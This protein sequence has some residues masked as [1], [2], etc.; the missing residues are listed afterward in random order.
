MVKLQSVALAFCLLASA[1]SAIAAPG[2]SPRTIIPLGQGWRFQFGAQAG[3]PQRDAFADENWAKVQVPHSWNR[4]GY[5]L[6][7]S[8]LHINRADNVNKEQGTGWYRLRF[9]AP[10]PSNGKKAWLQFDAA[11]RT[12]EVW[13]NGVRLGEHRGGFSRFRFDATK[14][15]RPGQSNLL[16]VKVDNSVPKAG[17]STADVLP[18]TGDFFVHGGLY[19]PASLILTNAVHFDM[20]DFGGPGVYASTTAITGKRA[21]WW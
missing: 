21:D 1:G 18:L 12:A 3:E 6:D 17:S 8:T 2:V 13:L 19:R 7:K 16:A 11:S 15:L 4:V 20:L 5:Y 14:A 10:T 9:T